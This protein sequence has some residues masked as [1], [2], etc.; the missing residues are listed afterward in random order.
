MDRRAVT[1]TL[2]GRELQ[3]KVIRQRSSKA[4]RLN[5]SQT[6]KKVEI[7][8]TAAVLAILACIIAAK[9]LENGRWII[10]LEGGA[11][12]GKHGFAFLF[13][14]VALGAVSDFRAGGV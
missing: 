3:A 7:C 14:G 10:F 13:L 8:A 11:S 5:G 12:G 1:K 9:Q 4:K 2:A 6:I